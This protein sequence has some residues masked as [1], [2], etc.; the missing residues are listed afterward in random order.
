MMNAGLSEWVARDVDDYVALA[1][2]H[3]NDLPR[4]SALRS[5]LRQQVLSSPLCDAPRFARYFH[6]ALRGMWRMWC[7]KQ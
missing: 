5:R 2:S 3:A 6:E 1:V 7:G 4:L